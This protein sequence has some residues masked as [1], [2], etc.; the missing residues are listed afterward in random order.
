MKTISHF[1]DKLL[2]KNILL[3]AGA[4]FAAIGT[5]G[6]SYVHTLINN[7]TFFNGVASLAVF[8]ALW[9]LFN[10][11]QKN[12][13]HLQ[14]VKSRSRRILYSGLMACSFAICY[15]AGWQLQAHGM[16]DSGFRGKGLLLFHAVLFSFAI[17]P[18]LLLF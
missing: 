15:I 8:G 1:K 7:S 5:Y 17:F 13:A 3:P 10:A 16:L 2:E 18:S 4:V 14:N 11:T 6:I 12:L 9:F